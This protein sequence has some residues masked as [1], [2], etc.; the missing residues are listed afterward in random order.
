MNT[1]LSDLDIFKIGI[2]ERG[3]LYRYG[4]DED[5]NKSRTQSSIDF[6]CDSFWYDLGWMAQIDVSTTSVTSKTTTGA[7]QRQ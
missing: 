2:G 3:W 5:E 1:T 4:E 7:A 6:V